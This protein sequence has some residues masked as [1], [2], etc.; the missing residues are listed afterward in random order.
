MKPFKNRIKYGSLLLFTLSVFGGQNAF[1]FNSKNSEDII[2]TGQSNEKMKITPM[3]ID[4]IASDPDL[5]GVT[6]SRDGKHIAALASIPGQNPILRIWSTDDLKKEPIQLG[7]KK[8]RFVSAQFVKNDRLLIQ[9]N[10][11]V[12]M[13]GAVLSRQA[14]SVGSR[15][16]PKI[17]FVDIEG[18]KFDE[19]K[20]TFD[21]FSVLDTMPGDPD[22]ILVEGT[23]SEDGISG[24]M[25]LNIRDMTSQRVTRSGETETFS[26]TEGDA[27]GLGATG[28]VDS[29]GNIRMKTTL[30]P[31]NGTWYR[32]Y[33]WR[34]VGGEWKEL[35]GLTYDLKKR[36]DVGIL[37]M[38]EDGYSLLI[39]TNRDS[40]FKEIMKYDVRSNTFSAPIFKNTEYDASGVVFWRPNSDDNKD[41]EDDSPTGFCWDGPA[42]ECQYTEPELQ[43]MQAL[44]ENQFPNKAVTFR[45]RQNGN[46][47]L[48]SVTAPNNPT[49]YF[50]LKNKRELIRLG[51]NINDIDKSTLGYGQWVT[52]KARDGLDI[53]GILTLP[54]GYKKERDGRLPLVVMPHGG[55][56]ARDY[57]G[58]DRS[59]W[60][61][62][63]ATRGFAV[64]QPQYRGSADLGMKLW[65]AG[66]GEWGGKMQDD[67][68]DGAKWLVQ[69]GIVDPNRMMMY[70]YSYGGFAA[71]AAAARS[72]GASKGLWQCAISGAPA[73]D[74]KRISNDWGD[75]RIQRITQGVTVDG[76]DPME[77]LK[78]IEIPWMI[79]HGDFDRQ[80]DTIHSQ[81][82]ASK[83]RSL[84]PNSK[85]EYEEIPEMSHQLIQMTPEHRRFFTSAIFRW[86]QNDCGNISKTF[87][88]PSAEAT[89]QDSK[90]KLG[91]KTLP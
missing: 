14:G 17:A 68:D 86:M 78:E 55:P 83:I 26:V 82:A 59:N 39:Q 53:P 79:F 64:L 89:Y 19:V 18:K 75:G 40:N 7:S 42:R 63:F 5:W 41:L 35:T 57:W 16:L 29:K 88:E 13:G 21:G 22:H 11:P 67:K 27:S 31:A 8:M 84:I 30:Y 90:K 45:M 52:Y 69:E 87:K 4:R 48:V 24:A 49:E 47:V 2:V 38:S 73:I 50:V 58:W 15:W 51:S 91:V 20:T 25:K 34:E 72:G 37:S 70:G 33:F 76:W 1:A 54:A 85:F 23:D 46:M 77:H 3:T 60:T 44:L 65:K 62:M 36:F 6:M 61:Q 74:L 28:M 66:D 71:A 10:Q 9:A 32:K 12:K 81:T 80:A 43:N 56:W